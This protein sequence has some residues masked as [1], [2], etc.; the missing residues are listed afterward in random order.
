MSIQ[1][2]IETLQNAT[3]T[4]KKILAVF[5]LNEL[6]SRLNIHEIDPE[7]SMGMFTD[8]HFFRML[9]ESDSSIEVKSAVISV[10]SWFSGDKRFRVHENMLHCVPQLVKVLKKYS[11]Y[12][13]NH[14]CSKMIEVSY[15]ILLAL[16]KH[17][18]GIEVI[19]VNFGDLCQAAATLK[20][21][22]VEAAELLH[23]ITPIAKDAIWREWDNEAVNFL[24]NKYTETLE[25][26]DDDTRLLYCNTIY[27][28]LIIF[29]DMKQNDSHC[30][31]SEWV[32]SIRSTT[33]HLLRTVPVGVLHVRLVN[34][35]TLSL[36]TTPDGDSEFAVQ[37]LQTVAAESAKAL[38][39]SW[40][41]ILY[42]EDRL[43][44]YVSYQLVFCSMIWPD[45]D[46]D[47]ILHLVEL[48]VS[49]ICEFLKRIEE[50]PRDHDTAGE[51]NTSTS[52]S[53]TD[54]NSDV[55]FVEPNVQGKRKIMPEDNHSREG[56]EQ[57]RSMQKKSK[58]TP[59]FHIEENARIFDV[60][61]VVL[62]CL[63][64]L[65]EW[66]CV[67][68]HSVEKEIPE[69]LPYIEHIFSYILRYLQRKCDH[70]VSDGHVLR[71]RTLEEI[72]TLINLGT[73][74][75]ESNESNVT[76]LMAEYLL[77]YWTL[78]LKFILIDS[79]S[80]KFSGRQSE[81]QQTGH[82][83]ES[84]DEN[85]KIEESKASR[86]IETLLDDVP[87]DS[88][89]AYLVETIPDS[90]ILV[91][92]KEEFQ[93]LWR[94][95]IDNFSHFVKAG[96]SMYRLS[97]DVMII[98]LYLCSLLGESDE[99]PEG[100]D[101]FFESCVA[102][103]SESRQGRH[104][105]SDFPVSFGEGDRNDGNE[106]FVPLWDRCMR[107][108][109]KCIPVFPVLK[110]EMIDW[111][112]MMLYVLKNKDFVMPQSNI[113]AASKVLCACAKH[114]DECKE[115]IL[116]HNGLEIATTLKLDKLVRILTN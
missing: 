22:H 62:D 27:D 45:L 87:T 8:A 21:G 94:F 37:V 81:E 35:A 25:I 109:A 40:E 77:F 73:K 60:P 57:N 58:V 38:R 63:P 6:G 9:L 50:A 76:V 12:T 29:D 113:K 23:E 44:N 98:G 48:C 69:L 47:D 26:T 39:G 75:S 99:H 28:M 85:H 64:C 33:V 30:L 51:T 105:M 66:H 102:L 101:P 16:S 114:S 112:P 82:S 96:E 84:D 88:V 56:N 14:L 79:Q 89:M 92:T 103:L 86:T 93:L 68:P 3:T 115:L 116:Q 32:E 2:C 18:A 10:L 72:A 97:C 53:E 4:E 70:E 42:D 83:A 13:G 91:Q 59:H 67:E 20:A 107:A 95:A 110:N 49:S 7:V 52:S 24:L 104:L 108:L 54:G 19:C 71:M 111:I 41:D 55:E 11:G 78:L 36:Q 1:Y 5:K 65:T 106:Q 43:Q 90:R 15:E 17:N 34:I 61:N 31:D 100:T 80:G 74:D 46:F